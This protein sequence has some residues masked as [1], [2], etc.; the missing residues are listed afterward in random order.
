MPHFWKLNNKSI[1]GKNKCLVNNIECSRPVKIHHMWKL[2]Q[3][4]KDVS[5][6]DKVMI[7]LNRKQTTIPLLHHNKVDYRKYL[8]LSF[9]IRLNRREK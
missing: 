1:L 6:I 4:N 7:M 3:F 5:Q 8:R 2:S 9:E